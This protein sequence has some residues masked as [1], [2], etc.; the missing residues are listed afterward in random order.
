MDEVLCT[1]EMVEFVA[2]CL[3]MRKKRYKIKALVEEVLTEKIDRASF[4]HLL[5]LGQICNEKR[6]GVSRETQVVKSIAFFEDIIANEELHMKDR[7]KAQSALNEMLGIHSQQERVSGPVV[8]AN[9]KRFLSDA[10]DS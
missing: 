1:S 6:S 7:I 4:L 10:E 8:A 3:A 9:I 2:E 5:T